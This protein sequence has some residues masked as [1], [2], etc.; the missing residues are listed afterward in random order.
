MEIL[1]ESDTINE[2][3]GVTEPTDDNG[4]CPGRWGKSEQIYV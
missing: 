2:S 1:V 3:F 4:K